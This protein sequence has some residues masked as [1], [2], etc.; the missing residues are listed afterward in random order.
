MNEQGPKNEIIANKEEYVFSMLPSEI[1]DQIDAGPL[2]YQEYHD[3]IAEA[4]SAAKQSPIFGFDHIGS[5]V[6]LTFDDGEIIEVDPREHIADIQPTSDPKVIKTAMSGQLM[7]PDKVVKTLL[8][9]PNKSEHIIDA[10]IVYY[11]SRDK[12]SVPEE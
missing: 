5:S 7:L 6:H 10:K 8:D 11:Q 9:L 4:E 3:S 1:V 2:A 12:L